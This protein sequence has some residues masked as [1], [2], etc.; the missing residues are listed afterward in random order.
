MNLMLVRG[1][2]ATLDISDLLRNDPRCC[3]TVRPASS[4]EQGTIS[5]D[6]AIS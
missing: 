1:G 5:K 2:T 3:P 6:T 4:S